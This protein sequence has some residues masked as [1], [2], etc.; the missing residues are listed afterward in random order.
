MLGRYTYIN[1]GDCEA[2]VDQEIPENFRTVRAY[3]PANGPVSS[4]LDD[5]RSQ[6]YDEHHINVD[7]D[8]SRTKQ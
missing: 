7:A 4:R 1:D 5:R 3:A 2:A 6:E 8:E